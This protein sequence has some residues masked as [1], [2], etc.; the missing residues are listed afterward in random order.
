MSY[1]AFTQRSLIGLM[2]LNFVSN[3][4][5]ESCIFI[6][7]L[8]PDFKFAFHIYFCLLPE[9]F[10]TTPQLSL[11]GRAAAMLLRYPLT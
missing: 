11:F 5:M 8:S 9:T 7:V 2:K 4:I 1:C 3:Q 6:E 10:K